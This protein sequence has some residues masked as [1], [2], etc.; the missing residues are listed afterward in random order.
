[1]FM[2]SKVILKLIKYQ[3]EIN[4]PVTDLGDD[5]YRKECTTC[6]MSVEYEEM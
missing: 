4:L 1:M 6:D 5:K 2:I 3:K